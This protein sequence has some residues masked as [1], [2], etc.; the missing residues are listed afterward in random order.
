MKIPVWD[1]LL[2]RVVQI[3]PGRPNSPPCLLLSR[4]WQN[5]ISFS[6]IELHLKTRVFLVRNLVIT[7][8]KRSS[9]SYLKQHFPKA[10]FKYL[11]HFRVRNL[12]YFFYFLT[13]SIT[14]LIFHLYVIYSYFTIV[15]QYTISD[16][17]PIGWRRNSNIHFYYLLFSVETMA[18]N[19]C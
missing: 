12:F 10:K 19:V 2:N 8:G 17:A 1:W 9:L 13:G 4:E 6:Q 3:C 5:Q 15:W 14:E 11:P 18:G 16:I 7:T